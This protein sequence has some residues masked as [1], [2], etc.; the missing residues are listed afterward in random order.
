[1]FFLVNIFSINFYN[2]L[3]FLL[4]FSTN[5]FFLTFVATNY[6]FNFNLGPPPPPISN[7]ASLK[8]FKT[9]SINQE[10]LLLANFFFTSERKQSFFWRSTSD[11]FFLCFVEDIFCRMLSLLGSLEIY[12]RLPFWVFFWSTY[13]SSISTTNFFSAHIFNTLFF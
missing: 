4:T 13:F 10:F 12:V 2:K 9:F 6:F 8:T 1:M 7:G 3:F 11:Y 5:F